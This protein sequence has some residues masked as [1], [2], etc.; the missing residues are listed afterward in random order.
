MGDRSRS[1][2]T[3]CGLGT[4]SRNALPDIS[5]KDIHRLEH[6]DAIRL[7]NLDETSIA[8]RKSAGT[9]L[10]DTLK[11]IA[12]SVAEEFYVKYDSLG[13][14]AFRLY[15]PQRSKDAT[16]EAY[17][18]LSYC[19]QK[20]GDQTSY[21]SG[22]ESLPLP[23]SPDMFRIVL[24]QKKPN[25]GLWFDQGCIHQTDEQ[26]KA[27]TIGLMDTIYQSARSVIVALD[28]IELKDHE[29]VYLLNF[30]NQYRKLSPE[31]ASRL[32]GAR[33]AWLQTSPYSSVMRGIYD[34]ILNS[35]WMGRAVSSSF[36]GTSNIGWDLWSSDGAKQAELSD[37]DF[38]C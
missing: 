7:L 1:V 2:V 27:A 37:Y 26:E 3:E 28:D 23:L 11:W 18:A 8:S 5:R 10:L 35:A 22:H 19:W 15:N 38:L 36:H 33:P 9:V 30:I 14:L 25:E 34:K 6:A 4:I 13:D 21:A 17:I 31:A 16:E 24:A 29:V 20:S 32:L 12:P